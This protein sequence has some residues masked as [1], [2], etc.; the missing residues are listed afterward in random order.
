M[1]QR[2]E[3]QIMIGKDGKIELKVQGVN[4]PEC[5]KTTD[6]L[7]DNLGTVLS[8]EKTSDYYKEKQNENIYNTDGGE[9]GY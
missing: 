5:I 4:G 8:Q 3:L 7:T 2:K 1:A 6:F 9:N